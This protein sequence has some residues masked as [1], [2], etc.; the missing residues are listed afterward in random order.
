MHSS[1]YKVSKYLHS[2]KYCNSNHAKG[3]EDHDTREPLVSLVEVDGAH[4]VMKAAHCAI[5]DGLL[6]QPALVRE[7]CL[8]HG[9]L[10]K[11]RRE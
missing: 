7:L 8:A 10:E 5:A 4:H 6:H 11:G 1:Y 3:S 9:H 2:S